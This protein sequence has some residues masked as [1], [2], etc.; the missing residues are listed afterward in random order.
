M[1][2][3]TRLHKAVLDY[4]KGSLEND[5]TRPE[6]QRN[7]ETYGVYIDTRLIHNRLEWV[8]NTE[9]IDISH[10]PKRTHGEF[11]QVKIILDE[12]EFLLI[13]KPVG[14]V[15]E[16]GAGHQIHNLTSWLENKYNKQI[17]LIN[18]LDKDTQGLM[19]AAKSE[20]AQKFFQ[21]QFRNRTTVKKYLGVV[22]NS[23]DN[24]LIIDSWQ[25]RDRANPIKQKFFWTQ[26]EAF[27]YDENSR[28]AS[29][30]IKPL[31]Y[32]QDLNKTLVEIEIKTGRMHQIR[33]QC[34]ALGIPLVADKTYNTHPDLAKN[35][36][37]LEIQKMENEIPKLDSN[38]FKAVTKSVFGDTDYCLLSNY[39]KIQNLDGKW[40]EYEY[41]KVENL[42]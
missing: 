17:F 16:A 25:S 20:T 8:F 21:D 29:S 32:N 38:A 5:Y 22:D 6:I 4:L 40:L 41:K 35:T 36:P 26:K 24:L 18:R 10:W 39:I 15:V 13:Y 34:E 11:E 14:V 27:D 3:K 7:I 42:F 37:G 31:A 12:P 30:I 9:K 19:L 2:I 23:V 28:N 33:V 1:K